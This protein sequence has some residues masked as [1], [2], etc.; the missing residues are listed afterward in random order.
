[1]AN[2]MSALTSPSFDLSEL[3]LESPLAAFGVVGAPGLVVLG[4]VVA[5]G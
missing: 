2:V 4:L 3:A 1:M 5:A